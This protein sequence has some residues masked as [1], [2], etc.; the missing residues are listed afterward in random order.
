MMLFIMFIIFI[1]PETTTSWHCDAQLMQCACKGLLA[2]ANV[3]DYIFSLVYLINFF[4]SFNTQKY[5]P[6]PP[7]NTSRQN[8][9][10]DGRIS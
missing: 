10:S 5:T 8:N 7:K 4:A 6:F 1:F 2:V 9:Q 3:Y